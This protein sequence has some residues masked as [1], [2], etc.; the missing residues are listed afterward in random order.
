MGGGDQGLKT[1]PEHLKL[2]RYIQNYNKIIKYEVQI[3]K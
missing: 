1:F 3:P 2:I